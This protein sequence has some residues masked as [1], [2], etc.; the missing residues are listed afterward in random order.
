MQMLVA[1]VYPVPGEVLCAGRHAEAL[2][3]FHIYGAKLLYPCGVGTA[4]S[5][6]CNGVIEIQVQITNGRKSPVNSTLAP[7]SGADL[8]KTPHIN[9][10]AGCGYHHRP[11][12]KCGIGGRSRTA[13]LQVRGL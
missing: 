5:Y 10:I 3:G 6:V 4:A 12:E 11:A 2:Q 7:L 8:G 1:I 13:F 9:D